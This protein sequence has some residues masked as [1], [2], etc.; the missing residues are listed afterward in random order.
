MQHLPKYK[1]MGVSIASDLFASLASPLFYI[2]G[3]RQI[4]SM[5]PAL[6][7]GSNMA[8]RFT[9]VLNATS[10]THAR[11]TVVP[12]ALNLCE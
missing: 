10:V 7:S 3:L 5:C 11:L 4:D 12:R 6:R 9:I 2:I 1:A 8:T